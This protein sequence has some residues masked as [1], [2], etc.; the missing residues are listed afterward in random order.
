M[1]SPLNQNITNLQNLLDKVNELPEALDTSDA[2]VT[3]QEMTAGTIA[4]ANGEQVI[5]NVPVYQSDSYEHTDGNTYAKMFTA[6]SDYKLSDDGVYIEGSGLS[7][8]TYFMRGP[9]RYLLRMK[10]EK[11]GDATAEDVIAGKTFTSSA[12]LKVTGTAEASSG[13]DLTVVTGTFTPASD[14]NTITVTHNLG[15]IP[16]VILVFPENASLHMG[17]YKADYGLNYNSLSFVAYVYGYSIIE[18]GGIWSSRIYRYVNYYDNIDITS[19]VANS[20][21]L[22]GVTSDSLT[23]D[24]TDVNNKLMSA[25]TYRYIVAG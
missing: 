3:P 1:S 4:Y 11:F 2:T 15:A 24:V 8:L 20:G 13:G 5:G 25:F 6:T 19:N 9:H 12:G 7:T 18:Y 10:S 17:T 22:S 14:T 21:G 23:V 16:K